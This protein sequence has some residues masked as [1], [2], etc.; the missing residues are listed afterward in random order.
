MERIFSPPR[1]GEYAPYTVDYI[2]LVPADGR[3]LAHLEVQAG[4]TDAFIRSFATDK[5]TT[6]HAP[7]EW[8]VQDVLQHVID[9]ERVFSYRAMRIARGD[10]T[11]LP[12]FDQEDYARSAGANDRTLE[13]L[14]AEYHA[15]R[16]ASIALIRSFSDDALTSLGWWGDQRLSVRGAVYIIAGHELYHMTSVQTNYGGQF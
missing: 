16:Q 15:V 8:T 7:A 9:T 3:V 10:Q 1:P 11:V 2:S 4:R 12:G 6:S 14:L 13:D 5:L